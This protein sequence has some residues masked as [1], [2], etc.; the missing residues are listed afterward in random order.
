MSIVI[1]EIKVNRIPRLTPARVYG[2][3]FP[4][5]HNL[6]LELVENKK[7]LRK[8]APLMPKQ[9]DNAIAMA[10]QLPTLESFIKNVE[11]AKARD[12]FTFRRDL[13]PSQAMSSGNEQFHSH[14]P[15]QG[16]SQRMKSSSD[17][18]EVPTYDNQNMPSIKPKITRAE[19]EMLAVLGDGSDNEYEVEDEEGHNEEIG[20]QESDH[21]EHDHDLNNIAEGQEEEE[22]D[23]EYAGLSPEEREVKEKEEY[24]W[25][26]RIL[27]KKYK[28]MEGIEIPDFNEHSDLELMKTQYNRTVREIYLD[29]SVETYKSYLIMG[30]LALE[31]ASTV[32]LGVDMTG[33][34]NYQMQMMHKY[35]RLLVELGEKSYDTWQM[36]LPVEIRL[37]GLILFNSVLFYIAKVMDNKNPGA[38]AD[39]FR[40]VTG[41]PPDKVEKTSSVE[42]VNEEIKPKKKRM[43]G[44]RVSLDDD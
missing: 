27:K 7:K 26:Y 12:P 6:H 37:L 5:L 43:R 19:R 36:N 25:R 15:A 16:P 24:I 29:E 11:V 14:L 21:D 38:M 31:M 22:E 2:I 9:S 17:F 34:M 23:D 13:L 42:E 8:N 44:P 4:P 41:M 35:E 30:S 28:N 20:H 33:F 32:F 39:L 40:S 18:I 3:N 1:R 10:K